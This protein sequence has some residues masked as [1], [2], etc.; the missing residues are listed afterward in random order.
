[1]DAAWCGRRAH[2]PTVLPPWHQSG[3]VRRLH[4]EMHR[5]Q[6]MSERHASHENLSIVQLMQLRREWPYRMRPCVGDGLKSRMF[7]ER[8]G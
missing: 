1:M 3:T 2:G 4:L 8:Y 7:A 5:R 6:C